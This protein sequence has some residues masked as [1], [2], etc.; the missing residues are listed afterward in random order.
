MS[1]RSARLSTIV[2]FAFSIFLI[3]SA[4]AQQP[5]VLAPH[6]PVLPFAPKPWN[7]HKPPVPRSMVGGLWMVDANFKSTI[8]L[9]NYVQISPITVTPV[10]YLSNGK[11]YTLPEM[12]LDPPEL[13]L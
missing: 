13:R 7:L 5:K 6:K 10:L 3:T 12:T 1:L 4:V 2:E 9:K 8:Y 11:S